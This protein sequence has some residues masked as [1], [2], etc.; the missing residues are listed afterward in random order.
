MKQHDDDLLPEDEDE[1]AD[2]VSVT[3]TKREDGS[4]VAST[5]VRP[6]DRDYLLMKWLAEQSKLLNRAKRKRT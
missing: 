5:V 6:T 2:N 4:I 1:A 3:F